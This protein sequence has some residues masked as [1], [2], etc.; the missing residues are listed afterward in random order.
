[1]KEEELGETRHG[2]EAILE[3]SSGRYASIKHRLFA[4]ETPELQVE[5]RTGAERASSVIQVFGN[6]ERT[7]SLLRDKV[8]QED[9]KEMHKRMEVEVSGLLEYQTV[10]PIGELIEH[11]RKKQG[12]MEKHLDAECKKKLIGSLQSGNAG[13][14]GRLVNPD[15]KA[16]IFAEIVI[17]HLKSKAIPE[18]LETDNGGEVEGESWAEKVRRL[19][20]EAFGEEKASKIANVVK[21]ASEEEFNQAVKLRCYEA[22]KGSS[23]ATKKLLDI[24]ALSARSERGI[25][26]LTKE[27]ECSSRTRSTLEQAVKILFVEMET[28]FSSGA[29]DTKTM[30]DPLLPRIVEVVFA[31]DK[32]PVYMIKNW[33]RKRSPLIGTVMKVLLDKSN[34]ITAPLLKNIFLINSTCKLRQCVR[35]DD[36]PQADLPDP[37]ELLEHIVDEMRNELRKF[38]KEKE[39]KAK[40]AKSEREGQVSKVAAYIEKFINSA[41]DYV[42]PSD[43]FRKVVISEF[44]KSVREVVH[45]LGGFRDASED[46]LMGAIDEIFAGQ[47]DSGSGHR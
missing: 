5:H 26:R 44:K 15:K 9:A 21:E 40:D 43:T 12:S 33:K 46:R 1:M 23:S 29:V 19:A 4:M 10:P 22:L 7:L 16:G 35:S 42:L 27:K 45:E 47:D 37:E 39:V 20:A 38:V 8:A 36:R 24:L 6:I 2:I 17:D 31:I 28:S 18:L 3:K 32:A 11:V 25:F 14:S 41:G 30:T 34:G 13:W